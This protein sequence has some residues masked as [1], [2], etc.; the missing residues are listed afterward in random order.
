MN[1][2]A[3]YR[4]AIAGLRHQEAK[5]P[6]GRRVGADA[7]AL[8][9]AF[10]G[11]LGPADRVNLLLED[12]NAQW[13]RAFGARHLFTELRDAHED[14]AF[15]P[16]WSGLDAQAAIALL[17]D[18]AADGDASLETT[19]REAAAAWALPLVPIEPPALAP[20]SRVVVAG[21]SAVF[22]LALAST[23]AGFDWSGRVALV[24][25]APGVRQLA[26]LAGGLLDSRVPLALF[27]SDDEAGPD[28]ATSTLFLG[29]D[30]SDA[31]AEKARALVRG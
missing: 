30:A 12:A 26:L 15:G 1:T 8:W 17:R 6:S 11:V 19:L 13:P 21:A 16:S 14:A 28:W 9:K 5:R 2:N 3:Y 10:E 25:D 23:E 22:A 29:R 27:R 24:A 20:S 18:L 31:E 7:D 4:A